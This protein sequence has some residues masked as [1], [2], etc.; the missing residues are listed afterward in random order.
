MFEYE[1]IIR[2]GKNYDL[3]INTLSRL[4]TEIERYSDASVG[5]T[6]YRIQSSNMTAMSVLAHAYEDIIYMKMTKG[7]TQLVE[8]NA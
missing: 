7:L 8:P 2:R 5:V 1:F 6:V 3:I 4:G